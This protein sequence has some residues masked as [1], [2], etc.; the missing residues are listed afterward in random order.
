VFKAF[1]WLPG[2]L[3]LNGRAM[4]FYH[5]MTAVAIVTGLDLPMYVREMICSEH[6]EEFVLGLLTREAQVKVG[7]CRLTLSNPR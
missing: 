3:G 2:A 6:G 5:I 7:R 4:A 1:A